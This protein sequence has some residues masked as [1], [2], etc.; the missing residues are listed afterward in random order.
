MIISIANKT[1]Y[2][3]GKAFWTP[4]GIALLLASLV[5]CSS[6][7]TQEPQQPQQ[8]AQAAPAM[9]APAGGD[10]TPQEPEEPMAAVAAAEPAPAI[11]APMA[12]P[13]PKPAEEEPAM[14]MKDV[15]TEGDG[16]G[17]TLNLHR[18][19]GPPAFDVARANGWV[20]VWNMSNERLLICDIDNLGPRGSNLTTF[21]AGNACPLAA[22]TEQLI[23]SWEIPNEN[24]IIYR[25]KQGIHYAD[26]T[27]VG[28][29]DIV[30]QREVDAEDVA[31]SLTRLQNV[32]RFLTGY[33][34]FVNNVEATDKYTV[35]FNL[36][37]F[38]ANWKWLFGPGWYNSVYP[39]ELVHQDKV[40]QWEYVTGTGPYLI[41]DYEP[42][43][44]ATYERNPD[45]WG[46]TKIDGEEYQLPFTDKIRQVV[47]EDKASYLTAFRTGKLDLIS[48]L[49]PEERQDMLDTVDHELQEFIAPAVGGTKTL[50]MRVD[51]DPTSDINVRKAISMGIDWEDFHE[52]IFNN[53][54]V[55][56]YFLLVPEGWSTNLV[57]PV[58]ELPEELV[59]GH[60]YNPEGA[61]AL[62]AEAG[63]AN[64]F[65]ATI[66]ISNDEVS[67]DMA[68]L[69]VSYWN[70]I[71]LDIDINVIERSAFNSTL[72]QGGH[73]IIGLYPLADPPLAAIGIGSVNSTY[74]WSRWSPEGYEEKLVDT[75]QETDPNV[76]AEKI[77]ELNIMHA[78]GFHLMQMGV[79]FG[80]NMAHPWVGNW[81]GEVDLGHSLPLPVWSRIQ[82]D[83]SMK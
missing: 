58:E 34:A 50:G 11:P 21:R 77:K 53:N 2:L 8:P 30:G 32:P 20:M 14:A 71:G 44:G 1:R 69:L 46:T 63:Y 52:K 33:W 28:Q 62:L 9:P 75:L 29:E 59:E 16:Y 57:T 31:L 5:A 49:T 36:N 23:E 51:M 38:N 27:I 22:I 42:D 65:D 43:V 76:L 41:S 35:Q 81:W 82:I 83:E 17:G 79:P 68:S 24:T 64:G 73:N 56:R 67:A 26:K 40:N 7:E 78:L 48:A 54:S 80:Y 6:A 70:D 66:D 3:N 74:N 15:I 45:Y 4:I 47:I 55:R 10:M 39:R 13:T 12:K 72:H 60:T 25:L 19:Q 61:K 18:T 37:F